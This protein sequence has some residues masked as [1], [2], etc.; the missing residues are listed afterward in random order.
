MT[1]FRLRLQLAGIALILFGSF[2]DI[3]Q[4]L[5]PYNEPQ[6]GAFVSILGLLVVLVA[7]VVPT[8]SDSQNDQSTAEADNN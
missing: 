6:S 7:L 8:P 2:W 1:P 5:Q 3:S 4:I